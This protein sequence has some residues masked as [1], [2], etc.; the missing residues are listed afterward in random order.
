LLSA[1]PVID[2]VMVCGEGRN[3]LTALIVPAWDKLRAAMNLSGDE[4]KLARDLEVYRFLEGRM[5]ALLKDV[6]SWEQVKKFVVLPRAFSVAEDE[7]TVSLKM[8]RN[9]ILEHQRKCVDEMYS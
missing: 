6:C 3:F 4:E 7:L 1:D 2:Q 8:R 9:I 5:A